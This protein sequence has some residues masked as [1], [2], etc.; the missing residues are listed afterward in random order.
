MGR[1]WERHLWH[2]K[3]MMS[4]CVCLPKTI[5]EEQQN[6]AKGVCSHFC[7]VHTQAKDIRLLLQIISD[8]EFKK[9]S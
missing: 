9:Q 7:C 1:Q 8:S 2:H 4:M 3:G 5:T 6:E